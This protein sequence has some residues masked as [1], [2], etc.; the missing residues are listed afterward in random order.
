[1]AHDGTARVFGD[2]TPAG[3]VGQPLLEQ[4]GDGEALI[5]DGQPRLLRTPDLRELGAPFRLRPAAD[6]H[7]PPLARAAAAGIDE[8]EPPFGPLGVEERA[9]P[10]LTSRCH[11]ISPLALRLHHR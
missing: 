8:P 1:M 3:E 2:L 5:G 11:R 4:L 9:L 10:V 6:V 7:P